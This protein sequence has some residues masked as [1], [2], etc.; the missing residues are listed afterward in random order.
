MKFTPLAMALVALLPF[1]ALA[2]GYGTTTD[3]VVIAPVAPK[4]P[5]LV[6]K[7][8]TGVSAS[9]DYFGSRD[10]RFGPDFAVNL[11]FARL[12]WGQSIGNLDGQPRFGF[13]PRG[14]LRV[15]R[16]RTAAD[17]PELAGL[18]NVPLS[19]ELGMGLG[20]TQRN[21]EAF[22]DLRYGAIGHHAFVAELG[23]DVVLHPSD[24]LTLRAGPRLLAGDS[25]YA[26]TYFGV[27]PAEASAALPAYRAKGGALTAGV[28]LGASYQINQNW[29]L[30]GAV[31]YD[32]YVGDAKS[33][34]IVRQGSSDGVSVRLGVTRRVSLNF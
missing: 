5:A 23:A 18:N 22:A 19:V 10:T 32:R 14:S 21:F 12:P 6:F 29:G 3:P 31:R 28:E 25:D 11:E 24:R 7:L 16:K 13:A 17:N 8:R 1:P 2:G 15:I 30:D 20:Y 9:P 33:S 26:Q 4:S 27:T 34:P